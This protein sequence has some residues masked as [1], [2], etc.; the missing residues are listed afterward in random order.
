MTPLSEVQDKVATVRS[1][2]LEAT[3]SWPAEG[4]VRRAVDLMCEAKE[5]RLT[6]SEMC[7]AAGMLMLA[8]ERRLLDQR[9]PGRSS[10]TPG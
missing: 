3:R 6:V 7:Q 8:A 9:G 2:L 1:A 5:R 4:L 10:S